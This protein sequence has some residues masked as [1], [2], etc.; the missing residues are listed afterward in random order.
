[1]VTK[2]YTLPAYSAYTGVLGSLTPD[3]HTKTINLPGTA[4]YDVYVIIF[5]DGAVSDPLKINTG[6]GGTGVDWNWGD[7]PCLSLYVASTGNDGNSGTKDS[8]LATVQEALVRVA[9]AYAA[10]PDWPGKGEADTQPV[11]II[12]V[13]T[14]DVAQQIEI[15]NTTSIYPN[16][17][18]R[19][20]EDG[21]TLQ[22]TASIGS[23]DNLLKIWQAKVTLTGNLV[24]AGILS[25][26]IN[27]VY[28][29]NM[30]SFTMDGGKISGHDVTG[31]GGGLEIINSTF[32]MNNGEISNNRNTGGGV[33]GAGLYVQHSTVIMNGGKIYE[34]EGRSGGGVSLNKS[35]FFM[36]EGEIFDNT[37]SYGGGINVWIESTFTMN[38]GKIYHNDASGG[39][40]GVYVKDESTFI[41]NEGE[42]FNNSAG[43]GGGIGIA[44]TGPN[45]VTIAGGKIS[46]NSASF[47]GGGIG[48]YSNGIKSFAKTGGIIYGYTF[49]NPDSNKVIKDGVIQFNL[50]HVIYIGPSY[51][52][53][54][55]LDVNDD[56]FYDPTGTSSG[57]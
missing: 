49:D 38:G 50:G 7:E 33:A 12:I 57:W 45:T 41:L 37:A 15:D 6:S 24:L 11:E 51:R 39:G 31:Y 43:V 34:N 17:I 32:T 22:A 53:E 10:D 18:L 2:G 14:V 26:N 44:N 27:G 13:D 21:G 46:G 52:K 29:T 1:V 8:P 48:S 40:G 47:Y 28:V 4:D 42:I 36:Y 19:D 20:D 3:T 23:G 54:T 25:N 56:L 55:T 35:E 30:S 16:I 5:K 9:A